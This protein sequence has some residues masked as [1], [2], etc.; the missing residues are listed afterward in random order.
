M[1]EM[2]RFCPDCARNRLFEQHHVAAGACPD[3]PDSWCPEWC[4]TDCGA[5]L[6]I[7]VT[8]LRAEVAPQWQLGR[9]VA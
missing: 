1:V 8:A 9:R 5:A 3:S 6:L 2:I 7:R 4:C